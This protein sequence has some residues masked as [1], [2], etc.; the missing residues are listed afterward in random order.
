MLERKTV[1]RVLTISHNI[2]DNLNNRGK[3]TYWFYGENDAGSDFWPKN[4]TIPQV[5]A[6]ALPKVKRVEKEVFVAR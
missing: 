2:S 3:D 6:D 4:T 1:T 5:I